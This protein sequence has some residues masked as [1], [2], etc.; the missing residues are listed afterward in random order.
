M[1]LRSD[2]PI[3][4]T[5][6]AIVPLNFGLKGVKLLVIIILLTMVY[7]NGIC[8]KVDN[9]IISYSMFF[10]SWKYY[11]FIKHKLV[12]KYFSSACFHLI[13]EFHKFCHLARMM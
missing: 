3:S 5:K 12:K 1:S 9:C 13:L 7:N 10:P 6:N 4:S 11:Y 2:S 8:N